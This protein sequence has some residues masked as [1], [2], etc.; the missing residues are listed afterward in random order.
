MSKDP[1][2]GMDVQTETSNWVTEHR[3]QNY[4][5]CSEGCMKAFNTNPDQY[6]AR[7]N[8]EQKADQHGSGGGCCGGGGMGGGWMRYISIGFMLL[9]LASIFLR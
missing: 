9:Y 3:G 5:F 6:L 8:T 2:C 4:Y 1:V 7:K